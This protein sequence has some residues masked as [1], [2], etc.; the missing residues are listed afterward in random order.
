MIKI[1]QFGEGNFLRTFVDYYFDNLNK[2]G[3]DYGVSIIKPIQFGTL[4]KFHAQNNIYNVILRGMAF[5]KAVEEVYKIES[6]KEVIDPFNEI[7]KFYSLAKDEELKI[8]VSNTT[9]AGICFNK[10]DRIDGFE[11]VTYP[12]KLTKFL[13]E[14]FKANLSGVYLM[15]VELIDNNADEL[16]RCVD[17]YIKLWG[18]PKEFKEWNDK[19]NFYCNTL[20]DRIV[21]GYPRDEKTKE[22]LTKLIG[23]ED[24]LM[25]VGEPFGLWVV[26]DKGDI[27]KYI[28]S[29]YHGIEIILTKDIKYYKKRKV[30]VLNGSH[31]NI[32]PAGLWLGKHTVDE[33]MNDKV[34]YDFLD[35]TLKEEIIP[36]VSDNIEET[37]DFANS[38][39]ERFYNPYLNHQLT[40]ILLNS[41]SKWKARDLPSFKDYYQYN[42]KIPTYLTKGFCYLLAIYSSVYKGDDGKYYVDLPNRKI[43]L[44]DDKPYLEYFANG[45]DMAKFIKNESVWGEDLS[46]YKDFERVVVTGVKDIKNGKNIL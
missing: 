15:P 9:E 4:D 32:V 33:V 12:A 29:G 46:Q 7:E 10:K 45:G 3:N 40:S 14:R 8:I 41:I 1:A 21:S 42:G 18:L 6:V 35:N 13:F 27:A 30:R 38:V 39:I 36:F 31:T 23:Y 19:E 16:Y 11:N 28:Q 25:T 43:E 5:G 24:N 34:L 37:T 44:V 17:G 20:V 26:E 22:H 2:E